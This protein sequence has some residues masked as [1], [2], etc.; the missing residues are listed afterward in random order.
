M[1]L[2]D[3][4]QICAGV[5]PVNLATG[6]NDGDWVSLKNYN[7]LVVIAFA[8]AGGAGEPP[9]LTME[10]A[11]A[12]A[13]TGAKALTFTKVNV[14]NGADLTAIG[15]FTEVTQ[16]AAATYALAA[17]DTQKIVVVEFDAQDLDVANG[18]DCVRARIADVGSTSQIGMILYLLSEPRYAGKPLPSAIVD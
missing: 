15:Q 4:L 8:G 17:G 18:F 1:N 2:L 7:H 11:T 5:V 9:T 6:A 10:Q 12:V 13:G 3:R 16:A 14:K